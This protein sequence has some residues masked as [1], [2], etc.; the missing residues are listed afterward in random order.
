MLPQQFKVDTL[1]HNLAQNTLEMEI[2]MEFLLSP[3]LDMR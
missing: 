3:Y 2:K 1:L